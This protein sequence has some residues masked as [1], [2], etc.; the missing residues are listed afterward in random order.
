M[1]TKLE[2]IGQE[3]IDIKEGTSRITLISLGEGNRKDFLFDWNGG[4]QAQKD[5]GGGEGEMEL[6]KGKRRQTAR[7]EG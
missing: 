7:I 5:Q 2:S 6:E 3:R 1:I 4:T